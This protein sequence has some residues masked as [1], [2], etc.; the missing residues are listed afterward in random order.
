[1][2]IT[3][4]LNPDAATAISMLAMFAAMCFI[5]WVGRGRGQRGE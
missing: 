4:N 3:I 5:A 1:M 2:N